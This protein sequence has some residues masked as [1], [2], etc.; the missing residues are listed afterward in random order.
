MN[1][2]NMKQFTSADLLR[3]SDIEKITLTL[4]NG[5]VGFVHQRELPTGVV[6]KFV[7]TPEGPER[8]EAL[9][10]MVAQGLC[11][12]DGTRLFE[13]HQ[14]DE[15]SNMPIKIFD[16]ISTAVMEKAGINADVQPDGEEGEEGNG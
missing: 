1:D 13:E 14:M 4:D 16:Q 10:E 6:I 15:L 12:D 8:G 7:Q 5:E 9:L 2:T 11:K 3:P